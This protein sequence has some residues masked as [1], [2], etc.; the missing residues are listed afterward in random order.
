MQSCSNHQVYSLLKIFPYSS[1]ASFYKR[2]QTQASPPYRPLMAW[3]KEAEERESLPSL[4]WRASG[5]FGM[6]RVCT[7]TLPYL[8]WR[9]SLCRTER[10]IEH[11]ALPSWWEHS[12]WWRGS[13]GMCGFCGMTVSWHTQK[14][15]CL[16]PD[17]SRWLA[18]SRSVFPVMTLLAAPSEAS[19]SLQ[20]LGREPRH[21]LSTEEQT[22]QNLLP[23]G[24]L[25]LGY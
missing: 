22:P 11:V 4:V 13:M 6:D 5:R 20:K 9:D 21:P 8:T 19:I 17:I 2:K 3:R 25:R 12:Y 15:Q 24:L 18:V 23:R 10:L 1:S 16:S 7:G 14:G